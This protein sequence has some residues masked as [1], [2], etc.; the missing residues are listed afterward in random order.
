[1]VLAGGLKSLK[2]MV[3]V[4]MLAQLLSLRPLCLKTCFHFLMKS[5]L[6]IWNLYL[7]HHGTDFISLT[8]RILIT[9]MTWLHLK[10]AWLNTVKQILRGIA[11]YLMLP[12]KFLRSGLKSLQINRF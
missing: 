1:M 2:K 12:V 6:T 9:G 10:Q 11:D 5:S 7:C 3:S 4:M 8:D